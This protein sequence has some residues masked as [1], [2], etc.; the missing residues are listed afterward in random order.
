ME[1]GVTMFP[2]DYSIGPAELAMAVEERG[3]DAFFI[4]DPTGTRRSV[5]R[6]SCRRIT[7]IIWTCF[8]VSPPLQP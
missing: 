4:P 8:C 7:R 5:R 2:T 6:M 1:F 3:F